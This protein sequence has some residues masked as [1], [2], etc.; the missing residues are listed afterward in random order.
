MRPRW[1]LNPAAIDQRKRNKLTRMSHAA[2]E[3][4]REPGICEMLIDRA[5]LATV[6]LDE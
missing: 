2:S 4:D 5:V 3:N 1:L 6:P